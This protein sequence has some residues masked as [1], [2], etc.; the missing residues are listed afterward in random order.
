MSTIAFI[1][2]GIMGSPMAVNLAKPATKSSAITGHRSEQRHLSR[3]AAH[4]PNPSPP[5]SKTLM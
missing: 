2:L 4:Q 3:R 1:G 5:Q